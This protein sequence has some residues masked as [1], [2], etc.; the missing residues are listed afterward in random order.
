MSTGPGWNQAEVV[1]AAALYLPLLTALFSGVV[2]RYLEPRP[3]LFAA[4]LLSTL[5]MLPSLLLLQRINL[6]AQ[7]WTYAASPAMP[8]GMPL[9]LLFGWAILWGLLPPLLM[10]KLPVAWAAALLALLDLATMPLCRPAVVLGRRWLAGELVAVL[11]VLVPALVL[12]RATRRGKQLALRGTLQVLLAGGLFLYTVPEIAF[13]LRPGSAAGPTGWTPLLALRGLP[14]W[15]AGYGLF[16]LALPGFSAVQEFV[17]RG[18]GTPIPYDPPPRLVTTGIY[19][20]VANP[21]QLACALVMAAWAALLQNGWLAGAAGLAVVYSAGIARWDE[22]EDLASRFGEP[23]RLYRAAVKDWVPRLT[24]YDDGRTAK[25]YLAQTCVPCS[26]LRTWLAGREPVALELCAAE[27]AEGSP[28]ERLTYVDG[29]YEVNGIR[30]LG[31][32]LEH[33][34]LGWALAGAALRLP[35]LWQFTQLVMD[36]A[37]FG[38]RLLCDTHAQQTSNPAAGL[39]TL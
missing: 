19:R 8:L 9:E 29:A 28:L 16:M 30:A 14:G 34:N 5:W 2:M 21:M 6:W 32:A 10:P 20:Y 12:A 23:W 3:R 13:A 22:R 1:R 18:G 33:L 4:A 37:G 35:G 25:L 24:P 36:V 31:R 26:R 7:W 11:I 15:L 39:E 17:Q 38:P 27:A